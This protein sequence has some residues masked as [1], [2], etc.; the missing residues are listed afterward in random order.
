MKLLLIILTILAPV[1]W[2][3]EQV[4]DSVRLTAAIDSGWHMTLISIGDSMIGEDFVGNYQYI[5][6]QAQVQPIR[7]TACDDNRVSA[8]DSAEETFA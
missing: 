7:F 1:R 4:G 5:V 6:H 2:S 8:S 3:G